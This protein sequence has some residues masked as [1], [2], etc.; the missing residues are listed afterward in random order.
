MPRLDRESVITLPRDIVTIDQDLLITTGQNQA[1]HQEI[2]T[3]T[4]QETG[5]VDQDPKMVTI[6]ILENVQGRE[7]GIKVLQEKEGTI[8]LIHWQTKSVNQIVLIGIDCQ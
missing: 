2:H 7:I 3:I 1:G 8:G 5:Y 6:I 4:R